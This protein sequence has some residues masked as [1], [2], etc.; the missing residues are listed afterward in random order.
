MKRRMLISF[1][2]LKKIRLHN[3]LLLR[4]RFKKVHNKG[5]K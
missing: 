5:F 3:S 2:F 4:S 1:Y